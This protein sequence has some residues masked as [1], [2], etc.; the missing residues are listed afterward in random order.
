MKKSEQEEEAK[1]LIYE[2]RATWLADH[3]SKESDVLFDDEDG[4]EYV[5][6]ESDNGNP[7]EDGYESKVYKLYLPTELNIN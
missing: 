4:R 6:D 2:K 3:G 5:L 7:G 1:E